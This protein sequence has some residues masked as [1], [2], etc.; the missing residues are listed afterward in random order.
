MS[1]ALNFHNCTAPCLYCISMKE[2]YVIKFHKGNLRGGSVGRVFSLHAKGPGLKSVRK[3]PNFPKLVKRT[4]M[5]VNVLGVDHK[6]DFQYHSRCALR[7]NMLCAMVMVA[8]YYS[9]N[10]HPF[11]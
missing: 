2:L 11:P 10:V 1:Y 4:S 5:S 7:M 9:Q 3:R 8:A 6:P